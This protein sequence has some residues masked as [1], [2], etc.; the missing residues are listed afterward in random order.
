MATSPGPS[1]GR[2][3]SPL[4]PIHT[5]AK[6]LVRVTSTESLKSQSILGGSNVGVG[7]GNQLHTGTYGAIGLWNNGRLLG[8]YK[9]LQ[10]GALL[11]SGPPGTEQPSSSTG[12]EGSIEHQDSNSGPLAD[13]LTENPSSLSDQWLHDEEGSGLGSTADQ[14]SS[15]LELDR[16]AVRSVNAKRWPVNAQRKE[17]L[18]VEDF[19]QS[20]ASTPDHVRRRRGGWWDGKEDKEREIERIKELVGKTSHNFDI[21]DVE[22][23]RE[24]EEISRS[25]VR[26]TSNGGDAARE[27]RK[28]RNTSHLMRMALTDSSVM[29]N[30]ICASTERVGRHRQMSNEA[31]KEDTRRGSVLNVHSVDTPHFTTSP[32]P[33]RPS[34]LRPGSDSDDGQNRRHR[35]DHK[36]SFWDLRSKSQSQGAMPSPDQSCL[37]L[38]NPHETHRFRPYTSR[39][40]SL[41]HSPIPPENP[42]PTMR[43]RPYKVTSIFAPPPRTQSCSD[44]DDLGRRHTKSRESSTA[45]TA[46]E[47][48]DTLE[49]ST[50]QQVASVGAELNPREKQLKSR[51]NQLQ[52]KVHQLEHMADKYQ[53]VLRQIAEI[54]AFCFK[55]QMPPSEISTSQAMHILLRYCRDNR[56]H[57]TAAALQ[58]ESSVATKLFNHMR[59]RRLLELRE[60]A[61]AIA[62]VEEVMEN[63]LKRPSVRQNFGSSFDDLLYVLSKYLFVHL[64]ETSQPELA[65]QTLENV[66]S[67]HVTREQARKGARADWF[68]TD[69]ELLKDLLNSSADASQNENVYANFDWSREIRL[70]WA[71]ARRAN[72]NLPS[73]DTDPIPLYAH[74]VSEW[75]LS[76]DVDSDLSLEELMRCQEYRSSVREVVQEAGFKVDVKQ[77]LRTT[78]ADSASD[79][80]TKAQRRVAEEDLERSDTSLAPA[81]EPVQGLVKEREAE[82]AG[83]N[84]NGNASPQ[85]PGLSAIPRATT[86]TS[87]R[88]ASP[89]MRPLRHAASTPS[90]RATS[91]LSAQS[92]GSH[93]RRLIKRESLSSAKLG[94]TAE[95]EETDRHSTCTGFSAPGDGEMP[96]LSQEQEVADFALASVCGPV[97]GQIRALD[98]RDIP[99][100]GQI[101]AA[102]AGGDDRPDKRISIWDVRS[103][104]LVTQLDNGTSKA[105]LALA[106]H[107]TRSELLLSADMEFDVKLWDW[108]RGKLVRCWKKHHTR[109]VNKVAWVPG[110][111][112]RAAS[113]SS[114]QSVKIWDTS[115]DKP[116]I[117]SVHANEPFTSFIFCGN[118]DDPMA[119]KLVASMAYSL[120]VY[121]VRT[122]TLLHTI[123]MGDLKVNKTPITAVSPHPIYDNYVL[124]SC[125][126]QV[127]LIELTT[128]ATVKV[129]SAREIPDGTRIEGQFSPHGTFIYSGT[130]D[131]RAFSTRRNSSRRGSMEDDSGGGDRTEGGGAGS[132]GVGGPM[133]AGVFVWRVHT[134]R[135]E[136]VE[137]RAMEESGIGGVDGVGVGRS[138]VS[139]CKWII[140]RDASRPGKEVR[141]KVLVAAGLDKTI[142]MYM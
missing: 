20:R 11:E 130:S 25:S 63:I 109:I 5:D 18:P 64:V 129:Y 95:V 91:S 40:R 10:G 39:P 121:K 101:I 134:G 88:A 139:V 49:R 119:Q 71:S 113:C 28:R 47:F 142:Q 133:A 90:I 112:Y 45:T 74:V 65:R 17:E 85:R 105:I 103:G 19:P 76:D 131:S 106:F 21:G 53:K 35:L 83:Y 126:N 24:D 22:T 80:R 96:P 67:P 82:L 58:K 4:P 62:F 3:S 68:A 125:D 81:A 114:D 9:A 93:G 115:L 78:T 124:L 92:V 41:R 89:H 70:F 79:G 116:Q 56:L 66:I 54:E 98:V 102:S 27:R 61:K 37:S 29:D 100:T 48:D 140:A 31:A 128:E 86:P 99:E 30:G 137:M 75:F 1:S 13:R 50:E 122:M 73:P 136:K 104:S 127:R 69:F 117:S 43:A 84:G 8:G 132:A 33:P 97:L 7:L 15:T 110:C 2:A 87:H 123:Q 72:V 16:G 141:R 46:V 57:Q 34:D 51:V 120:R 26:G 135:L 60:F 52:G 118:P 94:R 138:P 111:K 44:D 32:V 77:K 23:D 59:L 42:V 14:L 38:E 6:R 107:P 55:K 12:D 108:R 36:E